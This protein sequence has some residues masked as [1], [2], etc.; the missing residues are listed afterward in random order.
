M[1]PI[2]ILQGRLGL[3]L[4][5]EV[6]AARKIGFDA[7]ELLIRE[8]DVRDH[9]LWSPEGRTH[10]EEL[11]RKYDLSISSVCADHF[12][13]GEL[14][15]ADRTIRDRGVETLER[16]IRSCAA[17]GL[18]RILIPLFDAAEVRS[19]DEILRLADPLERCLSRAEDEGVDLSLE[20]T[21]PAE[22]VARFVDDVGHPRLKIYYDVGNASALGYNVE[23]EL[24]SVGSKISG[25][26]LK[27]RKRNGPNVPMGEGC[28]DFPA[29]FRALRKLPYEGPLIL[30]T[31]TGRNPMEMGIRHLE[32]V[33]RGLKEEIAGNG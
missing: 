9:P 16:L 4:D 32:F 24:G 33:R 21:L 28:V 22:L 27:D 18:L 31:T 15:S 11:A 20:T 14:G 17:G 10:L 25:V 26:H 23:S 29:A 1:N 13:L 2:G 8:G 12:K 5:P 30:E 19:Y 3:P 7:F 6:A